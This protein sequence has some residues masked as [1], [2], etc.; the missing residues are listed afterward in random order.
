MSTVILDVPATSG[1]EEKT[2]V[3]AGQLERLHRVM[4]Y[5]QEHFREHPTLRALAQI[6]GLSPFHFHRLF[7]HCY[8]K[9][10]K[11]VNTELQVQHAIEL[12]R[13]GVPTAEVGV[14]SGFANQSHFTSRFKLITGLPPATWVRKHPH[15]A[16]AHNMVHQRSA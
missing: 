9:T 11:R 7:R 8:G 16:S 2:T 10:I 5:L 1:C 14:R 12:L 6:A 15:G 13:V 3:N 4:Q